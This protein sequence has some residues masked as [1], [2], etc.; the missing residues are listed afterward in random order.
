MHRE[1]EKEC[2]Q[3]CSNGDGAVKMARKHSQKL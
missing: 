2:I 1:N 3:D